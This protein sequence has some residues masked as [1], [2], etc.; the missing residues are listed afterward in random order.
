M[1]NLLKKLIKLPISRII[2]LIK[3]FLV[4]LLQK[5][6]ISILRFKSYKTLNESLLYEKKLSDDSILRIV[7]GVQ[8][9]ATK[10]P[11]GF[12]CL[13]QAT[14]VKM[15]IGKQNNTQICIGVRKN[16]EQ[17]FMAHAW[18]MLNNKIIIGED[19]TFVPILEWK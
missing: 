19:N 2:L 5:V 14:A 10:I 17:Q 6:M 9:I 4:L 15:L 13:I 8:V 3:V 16:P 1:I 12:S 18:V 11:F 7:W